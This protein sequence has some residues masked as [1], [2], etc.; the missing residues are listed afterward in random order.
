MIRNKR[1]QVK[2][3]LHIHRRQSDFYTSVITNLIMARSNGG[4]N[5][6]AHGQENLET[7]TQRKVA[8]SSCKQKM[9]FYRG[10]ACLDKL[11]YLSMSI[12]C[13]LSSKVFE[14]CAE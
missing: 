14:S 3:N 5:Y 7:S 10:Q 8:Y 6:Y 12:T 2:T 9:M 13:T 11:A 4:N 1:S